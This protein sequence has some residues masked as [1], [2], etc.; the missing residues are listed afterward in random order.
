MQRFADKD[1]RDTGKSPYG[2]GYRP[3]TLREGCVRHSL[4]SHLELV[5]V[6]DLHGLLL[7]LPSFLLNLTNAI[8]Q[9]DV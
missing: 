9:N 4:Q 1:V 7:P 5:G 3:P 8:G 2:G 6:D